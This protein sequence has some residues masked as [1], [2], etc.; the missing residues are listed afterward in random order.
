MKKSLYF[1]LLLLIAC[2]DKSS[3]DE[4]NE[5][6]EEEETSQ[7]TSEP[8]SEPSLEPSDEGDD[9][10]SNNEVEDCFGGC[11]PSSW[12]GD[13]ECDSVLDCA[14]WNYDQGDCSTSSNECGS[15]NAT[16]FVVNVW[17]V[18]TTEE[19]DGASWDIGGGLPDP[20]VCFYID[21][22]GLGCS[23]TYENTTEPAINITTGSIAPGAGLSIVFFDE[24]T[25]DYEYM[26]GLDLSV[27]EL[28][29]LVYCGSEWH[30][31]SE[32]DFFY[33]VLVE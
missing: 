22:E 29:D 5:D 25:T 18:E 15:S 21:G 16:V 27:G 19:L 9:G 4:D 1:P 28:Q 3:I 2:T 30:Q 32:V 7:P 33:E 20:L 23:Q 24:D 14:Q 26:D 12:L 8:T 6:N 17:G 13:G 31:G 11:T 10:C